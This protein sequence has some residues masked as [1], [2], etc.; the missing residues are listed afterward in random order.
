MQWCCVS[1][2]VPFYSS[3][4]FSLCTVTGSPKRSRSLV[5]VLMT[6][7]DNYCTNTWKIAIAL[8]WLTAWIS[9]LDGLKIGKYVEDSSSLHVGI[10]L[11]CKR[12]LL[13]LG[14]GPLSLHE[15]IIASSCYSSSRSGTTLVITPRYCWQI[16]EEKTGGLPKS[17]NSV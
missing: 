15:E 17:R 2:S 9:N 10:T 3:L 6:A 14:A 1:N 4:S 8:M 7:L 16:T 11:A 13:G 12:I 5:T